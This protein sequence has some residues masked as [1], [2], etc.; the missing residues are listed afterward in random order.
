MALKHLIQIQNQFY[1]LEQALH[2]VHRFRIFAPLAQ[3]SLSGVS[4][5][6]YRARL[7]RQ[8]LN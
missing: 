1:R 4:T 2:F 7:K 3:V 5:G 8:M 6:K